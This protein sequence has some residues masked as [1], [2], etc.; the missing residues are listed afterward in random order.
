M[1]VKRKTRLNSRLPC[2]CL[3]VLSFAGINVGR[4]RQDRHKQFEIF[5]H[6]RYASASIL[7]RNQDCVITIL[8]YLRFWAKGAILVVN[9]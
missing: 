2:T 8:L 3:S 4:G 6:C 5:S 7:P 9:C 1:S